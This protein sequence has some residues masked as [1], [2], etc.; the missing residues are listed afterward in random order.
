MKDRDKMHSTIFEPF[1]TRK[2]AVILDGGFATQLERL[3]KDL[4]QVSAFCDG[5]W[6]RSMCI[7]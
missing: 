4:S 3:G 7:L 2:R 6:L 1:L 5:C